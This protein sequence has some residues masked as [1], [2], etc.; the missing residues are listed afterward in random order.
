[1]DGKVICEPPRFRDSWNELQM[2]LF[3]GSAQST[4]DKK[5]IAHLAAATR[6]TTVSFDKANHANRNRHGTGCAT[7]FAADYVDFEPLRGPAQSAIQLLH[8]FNLRLLRSHESDQ[9][10]LRQ[11]RC[12]R[13]IAER[14]HHRFPA[15]VARV[16]R[17]QE[18][19]ACDNAIGFEHKKV[20]AIAGFHHCAIITQ[21]VDDRFCERKIR[22]KLAEQLVFSD[23]AQ[24]HCPFLAPLALCQFEPGALPQAM[25][26]FAPL[27]PNSRRLME[28]RSP[29]MRGQ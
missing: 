26:K 29:E 15:D 3:H 11:G 22:Q 7:R 24:F 20:A 10:K 12:C 6:D 21:A 1:M 14:T 17:C 25:D 27:T 9:G 18:M 2:L 13:K 23:L 28:K 19:H 5:I 16:R 8:P 4:S